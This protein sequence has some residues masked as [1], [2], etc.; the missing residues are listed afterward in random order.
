MTT[1]TIDTGDHGELRIDDQATTGQA[2]VDLYIRSTSVV[3]VPSLG[4]GY[5]LDD[6]S[7]SLQTF[8]FQPTTLWQHLGIAY[9]GH[10]SQI[11][12]HLTDTGTAQLGGPTDLVVDLAAVRST[13][14]ILLDS[15]GVSTI[16]SAKAFVNVADVWW[17]ADVFVQTNSNWAKVL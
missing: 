8:N 12:L 13:V 17:P 16:V 7:P 1:Y 14:S 4:W 6:D 9:V 5:A 10:A 3:S 2:Y 15:F 11:T